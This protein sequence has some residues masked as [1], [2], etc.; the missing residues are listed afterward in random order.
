MITRT[1]ITT[2]ITFIFLVSCK[3]N[4]NYNKIEKQK[5]SSLKV[6]IDKVDTKID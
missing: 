6:K 5:G 1:L 3:V 2:F 4:E